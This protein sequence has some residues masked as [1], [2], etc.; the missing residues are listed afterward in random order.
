MLLSTY[1]NMLGKA[2]RAKAASG[3]AFIFSHHITTGP[4]SSMY[5]SPPSYDYKTIN[6]HRMYEIRV[7]I[8][9]LPND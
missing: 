9:A 8:D 3:R 5:I 6:A 2:E 7:K 4:R 1:L